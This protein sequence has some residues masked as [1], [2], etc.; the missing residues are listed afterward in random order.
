MIFKASNYLRFLTKESFRIVMAAVLKFEDQTIKN[1]YIYTFCF[2]IGMFMEVLLKGETSA[3]PHFLL[4]H[5]LINSTIGFGLFWSIELAARQVVFSEKTEQTKRVLRMI[6][7]GRYMALGVLFYFL[8]KFLIISDGI[9][10]GLI[11]ISIF[12][13]AYFVG[14]WFNKKSDDTKSKIDIKMFDLASYGLIVI[15]AFCIGYFGGRLL[16]GHLDNAE[17]GSRIGLALGIVATLVLGLR[18]RKQRRDVQ[19]AQDPKE[20]SLLRLN[21]DSMLY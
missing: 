16:G 4:P 17:I 7:L 11:F 13:G 18:V 3:L 6:Y 21:S 1:I 8:F 5:F 12:C 14:N 19:Q 10:F 15:G 2:T 9:I 20:D